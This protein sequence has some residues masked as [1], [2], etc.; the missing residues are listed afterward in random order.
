MWKGDDRVVELAVSPQKDIAVLFF[1]ESEREE[2][3]L[4]LHEALTVAEELYLACRVDCGDF[5][6]LHVRDNSV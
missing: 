6:D 4:H 5:L 1:A 2:D 3:D